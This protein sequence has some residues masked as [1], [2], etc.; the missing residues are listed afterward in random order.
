MVDDCYS[1]FMNNAPILEAYTLK[2]YS[3]LLTVTELSVFFIFDVFLQGLVNTY[4]KL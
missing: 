4:T 1:Y 2:V 3:I